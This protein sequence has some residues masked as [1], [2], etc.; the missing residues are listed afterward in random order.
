[1]ASIFPY[2][3]TL[4][5]PYFHEIFNKIYEKGRQAVR[6]GRFRQGIGVVDVFGVEDVAA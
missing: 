2:L 1:L 4:R 5:I 3:L 6:R